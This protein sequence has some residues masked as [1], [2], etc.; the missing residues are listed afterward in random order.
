MVPIPSNCDLSGWDTS[1]ITDMHNLPT[2]AGMYIQM[3]SLRY[4]PFI[5]NVLAFFPDE[6]NVVQTHLKKCSKNFEE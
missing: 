1:T 4:I 3:P 6:L 5:A 2:S